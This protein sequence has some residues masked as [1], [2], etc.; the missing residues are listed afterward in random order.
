MQAIRL[1]A[2]GPPEN[3]QRATLPDPE[4]GPGQL[5][6]NVEAS[7]VNPIDTK[8]RAG[9]VPAISPEL[10]A[11]L[12]GDLVGT[13]AGLG[14]DV[15][16]WDL[17]QRVW[18]CIGGVKGL[19]GALAEQVAV[20]AC[21]VTRAPQKLSPAKAAA[22]PLVGITAWQAIVE[23]ARI[24]P[25]QDVLIHGATGGVG[26]VALQLAKIAGAHVTA[27]VST[28]AKVPVA[29][30]LG[31][32]AIVVGRE[33][34]GT[35]DAVIDTL[36][37]ENLGRSLRQIRPEGT[38]VTI[39]A[40]TSADLTPLHGKA[41][42]LHVV[43]MLLPLLT[44]R[45]REH[46]GRTLERLAALVDQDK[47]IPLVDRHFPFADTAAAHAHLESGRHTGKILLQGW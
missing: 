5:L 1:N 30:K 39:A 34:V 11:I 23:R 14:S 19:P 41:G 25:G 37:G 32:D 24:Q 27:S 28:K 42:T 15:T 7:S 43:F 40:R 8:I 36:G 38:V 6:L 2:F 18:G 9:A 29:E 20:D 22:L 44:G 35:F 17:E 26:H 10:P 46:L 21:L 33:P 45:G 12:H 16:G 47:L 13:I 3:L 31:A 4:P